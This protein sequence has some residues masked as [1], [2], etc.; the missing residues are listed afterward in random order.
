MRRVVVTGLGVLA[1]NGR[2]VDDFLDSLQTGKSG[3]RYL[4][5]LKELKFRC[6]V[7]GIP[8]MDESVL[9]HFFSDA[10]FQNIVSLSIKYGCIATQEA[11]LDANLP[12][13]PEE[14]DWDM[15]CVYGH[16]IGDFLAMKEMITH[17]DAGRCRNMGSKFT[18]QAMNSGPAAMLTQLFGPGSRVI[19]NSSACSTGTESILMAYELIKSGKAL[20]MIAGSAESANEYTWG[21]F[22][23]MRVLSAKYNDQPEQATRPLSASSCGFAPGSGAATLILE[24]LESA[25]ARGAKIYCEIK[26]G[27]YNSGGQRNGGSMTAP[28]VEGVQRCIKNTLDDA[29]IKPQDID[30]ISGHLTATFADKIE[31]NNWVSALGLGQSDFPHI[32]SMK[33]MT[34]H[35]VG[36]AGSIESVGAILQMQH[37]FIH[38]SLNCEDL[39]PE[40]ADMIDP[41][42]IPHHRIDKALNTVISANFGF[43]DVNSCIVFQKI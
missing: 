2:N 1:P 25:Q 24:E 8:E 34:G 39:N 30:L 3:I 6:H 14:T 10:A 28:N 4:E 23:S 20:R 19:T 17:V 37:S 9:K 15:G 41:E 27:D 7:A 42:C 11:L 5:K 12:I 40:I 26:G 29:N 32:N 21:G 43:G 18:S 31:V 36:A 13:N 22:D 38:P 33:S 35:C 16:C